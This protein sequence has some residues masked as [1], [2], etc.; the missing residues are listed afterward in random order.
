MDSVQSTNGVADGFVSRIIKFFFRS[1]L[2]LG[3]A[4]VFVLSILIVLF[5]TGGIAPYILP[6]NGSLL[7]YFLAWKLARRWK[8]TIYSVENI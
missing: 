6:I 5:T 1:P 7:V 8:V 4:F 2:L 3:V